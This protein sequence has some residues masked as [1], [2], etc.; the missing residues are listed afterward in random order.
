MKID[1]THTFDAPRH[2]VWEALLDPEV[3]AS[4]MPG[5]EK[6]ERTGE[7]AYHGTLK[8]KVGPVQGLFDGKVRLAD[9]EAPKGYT[10]KVDGRGATGF[11][12]ADSTVKLEATSDA[13]TEMVYTA[14]AKVG[15]RIAS[16]GQRLLDSSAKAIIKQS[17]EGLN[18]VVKARASAE[19]GATETDG[20]ASTP[21]PAVEAPTQ[22]DFAKAVAKEVA[23]DL[24]PKPYRIP[25]VLGVIVIITLIL[26]YFLG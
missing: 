20:E 6:L 23:A 9:L 1:G 16:V 2:A 15:G 3:L 8:I 17:L 18:R 7:N 22:A 4:V 24:I 5:C 26:W 11:V 10:M 13:Q 21:V 19:T 25:L 14:D 12:R